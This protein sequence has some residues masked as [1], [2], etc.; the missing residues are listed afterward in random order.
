MAEHFDLVVGGGKAGKSLAMLRAKKS[1]RVLMVE[2]DKVGETCIDVA[3]IPIKTLVTS[4]RVLNSVR[5]SAG[6]G[7]DADLKNAQISLEA[8]RA[9][10]EGVVSGMVAAHEKMFAADNLDFVKGTARFVGP[11]TI[12][13]ELNDGGARTVEGTRVLIST[14]TSPA[15]PAIPGLADVDFWTSEDL[16]RLPEIP[17]HLVILGGGVIGVEF[18]SMLA[19]FGSRVTLVEGGEHILGR[20]DA[21]V[22]AEITKNLEAQGVEIVTGARA[23]E[24]RAEGSGVVVVT[25]AGEYRGTRLLVAL[26]LT[27]V[28]RDLGL[29]VAG[30]ELTERG[31]VAVNDRLETSAE[32]VYA[33]GNVAG[34]PQFTHVSWN[35]FRVLRDLFDGREASTAGRLVP[36]EVCAT[37]ELGRVGMSEAEALAAG[38]DVRVA[39][40]PIMAEGLNIVLDAMPAK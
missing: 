4:A 24:V 36:W 34:S 35:D 26:G 3:C 11:K 1:D 30:V 22:A 13:I 6:Y 8:L 9:R 19:T 18:A 39:K 23:T 38:F 37:S 33:A 15:V 27:P 31:F 17:E 32:G 10:K 2:R 7:V 16:L 29:E 5:D 21:D 14:G 28:T 40:T 20:E 25:N 12:E